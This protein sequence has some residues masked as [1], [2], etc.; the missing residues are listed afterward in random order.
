MCRALFLY[1]HFLSL[2]EYDSSS[3]YSLSPDLH[4][5]NSTTTFALVE[6]SEYHSSLHLF[7]GIRT[8]LC[9]CIII[10]AC[11]LFPIISILMFY[12]SDQR[13]IF[14]DDFNLNFTPFPLSSS[15]VPSLPLNDQSNL[16]LHR[17]NLILYF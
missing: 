2:F 9:T 11:V 15:L 8:Y 6:S 4:P 7:A 3:L 17:M 5:S 13:L 12:S 10:Y 1:L 16:P 14:K